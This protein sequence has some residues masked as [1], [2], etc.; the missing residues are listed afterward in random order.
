MTRLTSNS[1]GFE[2]LAHLVHVGTRVARAGLR[3]LRRAGG[4]GLRFV[5]HG[6]PAAR[7]WLSGH[8][9]QQTARS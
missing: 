5:E 1:A 2:V 6:K 8:G 7:L 3:G 4:P 9:G